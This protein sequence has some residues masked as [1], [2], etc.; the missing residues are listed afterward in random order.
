MLAGANKNTNNN[1]NATN[2][3]NK[4][5]NNNNN[6]NNSGCVD[7]F[8]LEGKVSDAARDVQ[9]IIDAQKKQLV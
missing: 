8:N 7:D 9:A 6:N 4:N 1:N 2:N 3:N 5:N